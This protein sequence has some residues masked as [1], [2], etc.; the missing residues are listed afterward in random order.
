MGERCRPAASAQR[1]PHALATGPGPGDRLPH[2]TAVPGPPGAG[3]PG[4]VATPRH[5]TLGEGTPGL[6]PRGSARARG[7]LWE[8]R[9]LSTARLSSPKGPWPEL[10]TRIASGWSSLALTRDFISTILA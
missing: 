9:P 1:R 2:R 8:A 6:L 5:V 10:P 3:V 7:L 4:A